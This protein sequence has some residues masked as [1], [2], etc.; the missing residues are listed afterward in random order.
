MTW[1]FKEKLLLPKALADRAKKLPAD[2]VEAEI[3]KIVSAKAKPALESRHGRGQMVS[4][5]TWQHQLYWQ[6]DQESMLFSNR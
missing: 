3:L 6:Q 4:P 5:L 2:Q 1:P